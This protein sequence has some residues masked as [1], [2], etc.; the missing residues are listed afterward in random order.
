MLYVEVL[1]TVLWQKYYRY[2]EENRHTEVKC[3]TLSC[4]RPNCG[5]FL[6]EDVIGWVIGVHRQDVKRRNIAT[7]DVLRVVGR[8]QTGY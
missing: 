2:C 6:V 1:R 5:L 4:V 8:S 7:G 3:L